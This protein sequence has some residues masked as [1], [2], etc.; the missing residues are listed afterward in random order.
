MRRGPSDHIESDADSDVS[1]FLRRFGAG[2]DQRIAF[3]HL[4]GATEPDPEGR[5]LR[6]DDPVPSHDCLAVAHEIC[7]AFLS[8]TRMAVFLW[9]VPFV[10]AYRRA[11]G[12]RSEDEA[13]G[14]RAYDLY[15]EPVEEGPAVLS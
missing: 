4:G 1:G 2:D 12:R 3:G 14:P 9:A 15:R 11:A 5:V 13:N 7:D 10:T 8:P 6:V